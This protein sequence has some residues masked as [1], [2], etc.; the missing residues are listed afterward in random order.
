M[1]RAI[2][3]VLITYGAFQLSEHLLRYLTGYLADPYPLGGYMV[4]LPASYLLFIVSGSLLLK[5][6]SWAKHLVLVGLL[7]WLFENL[8]SLGWP[9]NS[10]E[11]RAERLGI[12]GVGAWKPF[13][14]TWGLI[15]M[16]GGAILVMWALLV[17]S[18][19]T[20]RSS[21]GRRMRAST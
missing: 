8:E 20:S 19:L 15:I 1:I 7:V 9:I 16:H 17:R 3:W 2:P 4:L 10:P 11:F 18:D 14:D 6:H 13:I 12:S 5:G 21:R